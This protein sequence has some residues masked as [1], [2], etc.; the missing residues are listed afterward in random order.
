MKGT[1]F[2]LESLNQVMLRKELLQKN[3]NN[4]IDAK[5]TV[6]SSS[7]NQKLNA[8]VF[9]CST[10]SITTKINYLPKINIADSKYNIPIPIICKKNWHRRRC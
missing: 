10:E 5:S 1:I 6:E 9:H 7:S 8:R 4:N 3:I 2:L